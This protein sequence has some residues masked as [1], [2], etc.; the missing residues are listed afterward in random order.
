MASWSASVPTNITEVPVNGEQS[1]PPSRWWPVANSPMRGA[2]Q[3]PVAL[4]RTSPAGYCGRVPAMANQPTPSNHMLLQ[5]GQGEPFMTEQPAAIAGSSSWVPW[6]PMP[7]VPSVL[8]DSSYGAS[9]SSS[10]PVADIHMRR[11]TGPGVAGM[12]ESAPS[13]IGT[14][15]AAVTAPTAAGWIGTGMAAVPAPSA[16]G[17]ASRER[18][19]FPT[20]PSPTDHV[21]FSDSESS[22]E[23]GPLTVLVGPT[24]MAVGPTMQL[25]LRDLGLP[26]YH[27]D[28]SYDMIPIRSGPS[29]TLLSECGRL[30]ACRKEAP[31][32]FGSAVH[33]N[34]GH[35][36][37]D[38]CRP[39]MYERWPGRCAKSFLCDFCHFHVGKNFRR[40]VSHSSGKGQTRHR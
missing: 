32:S 23:D 14:G 25:L 31:L 18:L 8:H 17:T 26:N 24:E 37:Q 7:Q 36:S 22:S 35:L 6:V 38:L 15:M 9:S 28:G 29:M 40:R 30:A 34:Y 16:A 27:P 3:L 11:W 4:P 1:V 5:G 21:L 13:R 10:A 2:P 19:P 12:H 33:I 20:A 39:C